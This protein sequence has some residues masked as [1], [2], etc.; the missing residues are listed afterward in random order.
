MI[1]PEKGTLNTTSRCILIFVSILLLQ[2]TVPLPVIEA[3]SVSSDF[4]LP[5]KP[6]PVDIWKPAL[7]FV[8]AHTGHIKD[9]S[10]NLL[11]FAANNLSRRSFRIVKTESRKNGI[12]QAKYLWPVRGEITSAFGMRNHPVTRKKS[13]HNGI[14]IKARQGT[15]IL[16]PTDGVVV[17]AGYAG[18]I[19]RLV[20][21][22]TNSGKI[23][24]F[25][26][27]HRIKCVKG[28]KVKKGSL[29][30]TV[31]SSG[32]ATGPHL[33][34]SVVSAGKYLNPLSFLTG[35]KASSH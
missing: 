9:F 16:S 30:G 12:S 2:F 31:G 19:G 14:D 21:I 17:S 10:N 22:R 4:S 8:K 1:K 15:S 28:Q 11:A 5:E 20:K 25:G 33:H 32:R 23:L 27:M 34:F 29:I 18:L 13:F 35:E 6:K 26:H 7:N 24:Y 3:F